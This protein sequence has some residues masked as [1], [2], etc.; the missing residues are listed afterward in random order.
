MYNI[1]INDNIINQDNER[2]DGETM[3]ANNENWK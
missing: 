2:N 1:N 3:K